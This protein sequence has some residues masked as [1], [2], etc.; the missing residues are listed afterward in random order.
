MGEMID[1]T[2]VTEKAVLVGL[3]T[4]E[5]DEKQSREYL[6]ELAF[7]ADTAGAVVLKQFLQRLDRPHP[8]TFVGQGKLK[9]IADYIK[10]MEAD[11][12]IFD[13]ELT[14]TQLRNIERELQCK[15]LDRT[16]LILDIF[17]RRAQTAHAKTQVELAQYQ[18]LLP[19]SPECGPISNDNG[20]ESD[21]ADRVKRRSR[22]TVVSSWRKFH[23]SR[24]SLRK[25]ICK[26]PPSGKT[27][28]KQ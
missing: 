10:V 26:K 24:N 4:E 22:L 16:N 3:I 15:I 19:G 8:V 20:E 2:P 17:A 28:E 12:V 27:G 7:L 21:F 18:Y 25:L 5:Q 14:P 1:T 11:T 9:E 6:S 23:G 13:D